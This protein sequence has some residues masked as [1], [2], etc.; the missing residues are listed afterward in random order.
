[1]TGDGRGDSDLIYDVVKFMGIQSQDLFVEA[2]IK[3]GIS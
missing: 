1:M 2:E 3:L